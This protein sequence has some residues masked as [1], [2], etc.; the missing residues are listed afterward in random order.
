M[1]KTTREALRARPDP[2]WRSV[3]DA[4]FLEFSELSPNQRRF[5]LDYRW[6]NAPVSVD[7][8]SASRT[9]KVS[10]RN[11]GAIQLPPWELLKA[12]N[13]PENAL[14]AA[15]VF[16]SVSAIWHSMIDQ[17]AASVVEGNYRLFGRLDDPR[18]GFEEIPCDHWRL[19][20]VTDWLAGSGTGPEQRR[21][22]SLHALRQ[23]LLKVSSGRKPVYDQDLVN[24]EVQRLFKTHGRFGPGK[25]KGWRTRADLEERIAQ[26]FYNK[27]R[28]SPSKSVLQKLAA[29][30]IEAYEAKST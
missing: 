27:L 11:G 29:R 6:T 12:E 18:S 8:D 25:K 30:G 21:A 15:L 14:V 19:Y 1:I 20:R 17:F 7:V 26:F 2:K 22:W 23:S 9:F 4:V 28:K 10:F 24:D 5:S 16:K 3:A 13:L